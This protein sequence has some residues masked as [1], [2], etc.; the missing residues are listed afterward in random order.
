MWGPRSNAQG[1][2]DAVLDQGASVEVYDQLFLRENIDADDKVAASE[3]RN[4]IALRRGGVSACE[5][6]VHID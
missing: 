3:S 4:D 1:C 5:K 6:H 2:L